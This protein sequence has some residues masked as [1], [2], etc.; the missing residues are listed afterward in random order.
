MNIKFDK[1]Y[2]FVRKYWYTQSE[3]TSTQD[4]MPAYKKVVPFRFQKGLLW[5]AFK[6]LAMEEKF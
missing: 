4:N 2:N 5:M 1:K 6:C 3:E